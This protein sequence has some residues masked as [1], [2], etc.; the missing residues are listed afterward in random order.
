MTVKD[1]LLLCTIGMV[2]VVLYC[3]FCSEMFP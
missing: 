2:L 3:M 1:R